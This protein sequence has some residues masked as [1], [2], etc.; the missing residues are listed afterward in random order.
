MSGQDEQTK[1][2]SYDF[3]EKQI[4]T[5]SEIINKANGFHAFYTHAKWISGVSRNPSGTSF[6]LSRLME[7]M[8][9]IGID[10]YPS[11]ANDG[12]SP[13]ILVDGLTSKLG[14]GFQTF[15]QKLREQLHSNDYDNR[16]DF[17]LLQACCWDLFLERERY[18]G[19]IPG[20][21]NF[22]EYLLWDDGGLWKKTAW[23]GDIKH[24]NRQA[25]IGAGW[26]SASLATYAI[27]SSKDYPLPNEFDTWARQAYDA[28]VFSQKELTAFYHGRSESI[29]N[30]KPADHYVNALCEFLPY[31]RSER[32]HWLPSN[33]MGDPG[34]PQRWQGLLDDKLTMHKRHL[35]L[36][37]WLT[38]WPGEEEG[39]YYLQPASLALLY[40]A[41][42]RTPLP[43][44][45]T[46]EIFVQNYAWH[47]DEHWFGGFWKAE[48]KHAKR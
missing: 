36:D 17:A 14:K 40:W 20:A 29:F 12:R 32:G 43:N 27:T 33:G 26:P 46:P 1:F 23:Q 15:L 35:L 34:G 9:K 47:R 13:L 19:I 8:E 25:W 30:R 4:Q 7:N 10:S 18:S 44:T 45:E 5:G 16:A 48:C 39:S 2:R 11:N 41:V 31:Y 37:G 6:L 24:R 42:R 28:L 21:S 3:V 38:L 22:H